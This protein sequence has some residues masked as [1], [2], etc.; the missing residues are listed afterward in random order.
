MMKRRIRKQLKKGVKN[1]ISAEAENAGPVQNSQVVNEKKGENSFR[2]RFFS[3][4]EL[5]KGFIG[6][7]REGSDVFASVHPKGF[8]KIRRPSLK[9]LS[10]TKKPLKF[11][12]EKA[13]IDVEG[14]RL[15]LHVFRFAV[16]VNLLLS[17]YLIYRFSTDLKVGVFYVSLAMVGVWGLVFVAVLMLTWLLLLV[18]I[19]LRIFSRR[20][21]IEE[22]LPDYLQLTASNIRAGMPLDKALWYAVRPRFG[23]LANEIE[24][25]AK[26]TMSGEEL[27]DALRRFSGKYDSD[28]LKRAINL[29]IEGQ[30]AG[31]EVGDILNSIAEN[32]KENQLM[33]KEMAANVTTYAIFI[34]FATI[35][36]APF[37]FALAGQLLVVVDGI[38]SG[39]DLEEI[40]GSTGLGFSFLFSSSGVSERDFRIFSYISLTITSTFSAAIVAAIRKG[41]VK[42]GISY[43]PVFISVSLALYVFWSFAFDY[44]FAGFR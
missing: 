17:V 22:V 5:V 21:G 18:F 1:A 34:G 9:D 19:D 23:V 41:S 24:T 29:L 11:Y 37:L 14:M 13:G 27:E 3:S 28:V 33:K 4:A 31:G 39:I 40:K 2:K 15:S 44:L 26:E 42:K 25:V 20:V 35:I 12:L 7:K 16:F 6:M 8:V 38:I 30:N 32:I 43:V 36:A 10:G